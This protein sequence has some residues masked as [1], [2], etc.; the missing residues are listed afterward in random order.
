MAEIQLRRSDLR[1]IVVAVDPAATSG[2]D[3]DDTGIVVVGRGP[4]QPSTCKLVREGLKC[5]GHG[6]ILSDATCHLPPAGWAQVAIREYDRWSADRIVAERNNGG[7]MVGFVVQSQRPGVPYKS[8]VATRGKAV[9]A[10]PASA[11]S[12]QGRIHFMG[13]FP[14][15][16]EELTTW[17]PDDPSADSPNRLDAMVWGLTE[18]QL[19]GGQGAAFIAAWESELARSESSAIIPEGARQYLAALPTMTTGEDEPQERV[20]RCT[21]GRRF[22]DGHCVRC[23]G[24]PAR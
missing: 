22:F 19:I 5:P 15:L 6:Y 21:V 24:V 9:R 4:C 2:E 3:A 7:D 1:H 11:M 18:L 23:G 14:E 20:C 17:L 10:E 13:I 16:E 12:E 8:V